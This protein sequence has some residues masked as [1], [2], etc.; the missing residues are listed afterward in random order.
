MLAALM[1]ANLI[2]VLLTHRECGR[3]K[4]NSE[5]YLSVLTDVANKEVEFRFNNQ[6]EM[7]I[8]KIL[9]E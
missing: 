6:G 5:F 9:G 2:Y 4:R 3:A 7:E 8:R 1:V